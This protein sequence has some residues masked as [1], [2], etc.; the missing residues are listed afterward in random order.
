[1]HPTG[2]SARLLARGIEP[3]REFSQPVRQLSPAACCLHVTGINNW[4]PRPVQSLSAQRH[5]HS[6][7]RVERSDT[8]GQVVPSPLRWRAINRRP[9]SPVFGTRCAGCNCPS[10]PAPAVQSVM[11]PIALR[12]NGFEHITNHRQRLR[13]SAQRTGLLRKHRGRRS[14]RAEVARHLIATRGVLP[15]DTGSEELIVGDFASGA[16]SCTQC[17]FPTVSMALIGGVQPQ[18]A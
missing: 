17:L 18:L 12:C 13:E 1:M 8:A 7:P 5:L 10:T 6:A 2:L 14:R 3:P 4:P 9:Q 11:E 16:S 15:P